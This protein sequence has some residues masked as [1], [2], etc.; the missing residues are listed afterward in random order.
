MCWLPNSCIVVFT[1]F[2]IPKPWYFL[3]MEVSFSW[4]DEPPVSSSADVYVERMSAE[5]NVHTCISTS[6]HNLRCIIG[7]GF[8]TLI[9]LVFCLWGMLSLTAES[10]NCSDV[11]HLKV[12][13]G[14]FSSRIS[15][16]S[17][18][19]CVAMAEPPGSVRKA[20]LPLLGCDLK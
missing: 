14:P 7:P 11:I 19:Y 3:Y 16:G 6:A 10:Y 13:R 12:Q 2:K 8:Q 20:A 18:W 1:L 5:A 17:R 15:R 4:W 9:G